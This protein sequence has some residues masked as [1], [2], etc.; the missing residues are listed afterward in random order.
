MNY[1]K[2]IY[3]YAYVLSIYSLRI[4]FLSFVYMYAWYY[5]ICGCCQTMHLEDYQIYVNVCKYNKLMHN[6]YNTY[7]V[8]YHFEEKREY[9]E[10]NSLHI[11]AV[12]LNYSLF[13]ILL[14]FQE[15]PTFNHSC[16]GHKVYTNKSAP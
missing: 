3:I 14:K 1:Q 15:K 4:A 8:V 2:H 10:Y 11:I 6:M 16:F 5:H 9:I 12:C 7:I 13:K